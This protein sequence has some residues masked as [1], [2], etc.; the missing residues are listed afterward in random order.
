ML[1]SSFSPQIPSYFPS[2]VVGKGIGF[3][4]ATGYDD[5]NI[6]IIQSVLQ[7]IIAHNTNASYVVFSY[8][9]KITQW[10]DEYLRIYKI[11][12]ERKAFVYPEGYEPKSKYQK[13]NEQVDN[14]QLWTAKTSMMEIPKSVSSYAQKGIFQKNRL[15]GERL[16][17]YRSMNKKN[18]VWYTLQKY[19]ELMG[20]YELDTVVIFTDN[21]GGSE[22]HEMKKFAKQYG[23]RI[24][25]VDCE[26]NFN[27]AT[28]EQNP[29]NH[30]EH[31]G[32]IYHNR[33]REVE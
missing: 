16:K 28:D 2:D 3:I 6:A 26:G 29:M 20:T 24:I 7:T 1:R 14:L 22:V 19:K 15:M 13:L 17:A 4:G 8:S 25:T 12:A 33:N 11:P 23:F 21:P 32:G 10:A 30:R 9:P 5:R 27:D 31:Y 18:P